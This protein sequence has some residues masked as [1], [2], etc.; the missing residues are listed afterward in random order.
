MAA[1]TKVSVVW[2]IHPGN[3][4][5]NSATVVDDIMKKFGNMY[6]L[7]FR[8]FA[9]F[10]DDVN[11]PGDEAT[12]KKTADNVGAIQHAIEDKWNIAGADPADTVKA[13]RFTPQIYCRAFAGP[14][15]Q[16]NSFFQA[17]SSLPA[18]V[19]VYYT[20][21][22]VWSVPN[23]NDLNTLQAQFGRQAIWWWNYPC[24]DNGTG[25]SRDIPP[26]T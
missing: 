17:M 23:N 16:Y 19:T 1:D 15:S 11:V 12:M 25:P 18:N 9:I 22:G 26:G 8:Q 7:G 5:M 13:L 6:D 24:N 3:A 20:G 21:G 10:A 14:D 2:A 4:I